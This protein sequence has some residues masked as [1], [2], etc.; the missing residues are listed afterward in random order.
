SRGLDLRRAPQ[1]EPLR[2]EFRRGFEYSDCW[3]DDARLVVLNAMDARERGAAI[4]VGTQARSARRVDGVWEMELAGAAGLR[5]VRGRA[6][7]N[8]AGPWVTDV[9]GRMEGARPAIGLRLV[10][11]SHIIVRR[12]FD[13][14][15]AYIL[16]NSDWRIVFVIPYE[17]DYTL[18][19]TTDVPYTGDPA[20]VAASP[21]E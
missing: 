15:Q 9:L 8:A 17:R 6:L 10:K 21:E 3:V 14:R 2:E 5:T 11:G 1:G 18:I 19:G 7:V 4:L 12:M 13:G 20:A 16:Q